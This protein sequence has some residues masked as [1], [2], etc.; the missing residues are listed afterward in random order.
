VSAQPARGSIVI[1]TDV[2]GANLAPRSKLARI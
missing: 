1:D 2:Y